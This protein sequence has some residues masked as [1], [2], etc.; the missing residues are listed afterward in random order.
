MQELQQE[1]EQLPLL[2]NIPFSVSI[3]SRA[4]TKQENDFIVAIRSG[5][6]DFVQRG[7][8]YS[9]PIDLVVDLKRIAK[10]RG[11]SRWETLQRSY[12]N[13]IELVREHPLTQTIRYVD[14]KGN[15]IEKTLWMLDSITQ[16]E[17][18]GTITVRI[19]KGFQEYY[20]L[21]LLR[22][23]EIQIDP[24]FHEMARS[25]Y[26]YPF[27]TW[28]SAKVAL[29]QRLEEEYPYQVIVP[30]SKLQEHVP[31]AK[32]GMRIGEYMRNAIYKAIDDLNTNPYS[33]L[34]IENPDDIVYRTS[35]RRK[36]EDLRFEVTLRDRTPVNHVSLLV[37]E[38]E[39]GLVDDAGIP[40]WEYLEE[41]MLAIGYG[42]NSIPQWKD[43]RAKVWRA[44]LCAWIQISKLRRQGNTDINM[45]GYLQTMLRHAL[46]P[47]PFKD[48]AQAVVFSAPEFRDSVV[49]AV[50]NYKMPKAVFA[51]AEAIELD[52]GEQTPDN[53]DFLAE[54]SS[55]NGDTLP[56]KSRS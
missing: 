37:G 15:K 31:P 7:G 2:S 41:K 40:S 21:S 50:A 24:K 29:M 6:Q 27:V 39:H 23:P 28:L 1:L 55:R 47:T 48:L 18:N 14:P 25:S 19:A 17:T 12:K 9:Q 4:T 16:D 3:P 49:D 30:L 36:I 26:T 44:L 33:Q 8:D 22:N 20:V 5:I 42:K 51:M 53:N 35:G 46:P 43:Q 34:T 56:I 32:T 10:E 52:F 11:L 54:W 13:T 38:N 45:G